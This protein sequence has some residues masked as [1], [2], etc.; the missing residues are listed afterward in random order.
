MRIKGYPLYMCFSISSL[1]NLYDHKFSHPWSVKSIFI[2][3]QNVSYNPFSV[4]AVSHLLSP[5]RYGDPRIIP[6]LS[7][8]MFLRLRWQIQDGSV[9]YCFTDDVFCP[10]LAFPV[11]VF[12]K[13]ENLLIRKNLP[14]F[15]IQCLHSSPPVLCSSASST[16]MTVWLPHSV[17][18]LIRCPN[19]LTQRIVQL[20]FLLVEIL[21]VN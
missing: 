21:K 10:F 4:S 15:A 5:S 3:M 2:D 14:T 1:W 16:S 8:E 9:W 18:C 17:S 19:T 7:W 11:N 6:F 12:C 20:L 13:S